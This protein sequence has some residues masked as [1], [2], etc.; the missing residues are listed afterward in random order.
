MRGSPVRIRVAAPINQ[1]LSY[2]SIISCKCDV[3]ELRVVASCD[4]KN[5]LAKFHR[6]RLAHAARKNKK[7]GVSLSNSAPQLEVWLEAAVIR[8]GELSDAR[9]VAMTFLFGVGKNRSTIQLSSSP[10]LQLSASVTLVE[11]FC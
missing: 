7:A 5:L 3:R 2:L 11:I 10:A 4:P 6:V 9:T 8:E 1:A